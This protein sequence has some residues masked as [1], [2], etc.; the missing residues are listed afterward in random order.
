MVAILV[1]AR[2]IEAGEAE[3]KVQLDLVGTALSAVGLGLIVLRHPP[4]GHLGLRHGQA[5][6][7][8]MD[9]ALAGD[10][11]DPRRR[12]RALRS[13]SPGRAASSARGG[14]RSSTRRSCGSR[15]C[16][17]ASPRSSSSTSSRAG[18]SSPMPLFLS[19]ALGLSAIET[20]VRLLP[21]SFA[22]ILAAA[23]IPKLFPDVSPRRV[24][25][26]GFVADVRRAG[27]DGRRPRGR[28]RRRRSSPGRC[29][30]PASGS[31]R[32]PRS[33]A[34]SPSPRSPTSRAARSAACRTRS[35]TSASRSAR[36]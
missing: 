12:R 33:S 10:L 17:R 21:L 2:R 8:G 36:R 16:A 11:A 31:A 34:A 35:P 7:A 29:S 1:L 13:S 9:R 25:R 28:R 20:G 22:L 23:G 32:S 6:G 5:R 27:G 24:V 3:R 4:L 26:L 30:W 18:C 14:S 19:I 15:P